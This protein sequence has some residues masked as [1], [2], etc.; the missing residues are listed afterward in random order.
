MNRLVL[1]AILALGSVVSGC[2]QN[3]DHVVTIHTKYGD[4][5]VLLFDETP[6]HKKNFIKL[7]QEGFYDSLL[8]HRVI[9]GFMIQGGDPDSKRSK[10][11]ERLGNGGPGYT[12][13]AE[14]DPRFIHER[15]VLS[16]A[17][18]GNEINPSKASSGSQFYI[19]QGRVFTPD[20]LTTDQEQLNKGLQQILLKPE[21]QPLFDTLSR[22]YQ[23]GDMDG[24]MKKV[25]SLKPR[26]KAE[27]GLE[28]DKRIDPR[29]LEVYTTVGGAPHLDGEY[30]VFGKVIKGLDVI[31]WIAEQPTDGNDRPLEN[32]H[33]TVTV[34]LMPKKKIEKL[35]GYRYPENL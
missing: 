25:I 8:F 11:G 18:L 19:V 12:V 32:I 6:Q 17:R 16:A 1:V 23:M 5:V 9:Q 31:D 30:T 13:P 4:M 33:M 35:Y 21:N 10:P 28:L 34:E 3:K 7:A 14:I 27:T 2:A 22:L 29:R 24:Y 20:E 26:I 15:G